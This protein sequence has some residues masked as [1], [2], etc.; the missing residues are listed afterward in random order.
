MDS[1]KDLY[2]IL[3]LSHDASDNDIKKAYKKLAM[4]YH[5]DRQANKSDKE[6]KEAEEKFKEVA[7]A[8]DILSTPEKKQRYD[9]F[10][11]TDDQQQM[12]GGFDPSEIFKHF[13]GGFGGMFGDNDDNDPFGSFFGRRNRQNRGPQRG[14]SIRMQIPVSTYRRKCYITQQSK[15]STIKSIR[16]PYE[17]S[18]HTYSQQIYDFKDNIW[19]KYS[20]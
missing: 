8:Y 1:N 13:M 12:G 17:F 15:Y 14:Q 9:Q 11:I 2:E 5:P 20:I 16:G 7:W 18:K 3:G 6:K 10:G 4:K 19:H